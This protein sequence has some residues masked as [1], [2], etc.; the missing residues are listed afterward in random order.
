MKRITI[1]I[2]SILC[3]T[4][5]SNDAFNV[6]PDGEIAKETQQLK[7]FMPDA[8]EVSVYSTATVSECWVEDLWVLVFNAA[9]A[10][11]LS[12]TLFVGSAI[13]N[14]GQAMQLV[15][16]LNRTIGNNELVVCIANSGISTLPTDINITNINEKFP[17]SAKSYY[18]GGDALPM[19][20]E[21]HWG[22][23]YTVKM[24]RAV[25]KVQVKLGEN[26]SDVTRY[27]NAES[28][29][30]QLYNY[31]KAGKIQPDPLSLQGVEQAANALVHTA[32][33]FKLLQ[34]E[35]A[36][37]QQTNAYIHEYP[38]QK[39]KSNALTPVLNAKDWDVDRVF[40]LLK[41]E[42][43]P[44]DSSF[45]RLDFFSDS[46]YLDTKR[47]NHYIFTINKIRSAGYANTVSPFG[48]YQAITHPG[49][50]IEY[51]VRIDDDMT[52][53]TSN[54]QY[55]IASNVDTAYVA[56]GVANRPIGSIRYIDITGTAGSNI[57]NSN[58]VT[59]GLVSPLPSPTSLTASNQEIVVS[60]TS[61][62]TGGVITF[63]LGNIEHKIYVK[64]P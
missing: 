41:Q 23:D 10:L 30:W 32:E 5:C 6:G 3:F 19:Y 25:A 62:F 59:T 49:S 21:T 31:G 64:T 34:S 47:N 53:I 46:I 28:V 61:A 13:L 36:T 12:D 38:S 14:N 44:G 20:G 24:T 8:A 55:G 16:Q 54:G 7:L 40:I 43:T 35:G 1:L 63:K 56:A 57:V 2:L 27:F 51:T 39:Q 29:T 58:T 17:L 50:N 48:S 18:K 15:P 26:I 60:T 33:S 9:G 22:G 37:E 11:K 45:Y 42:P 4:A 52:Y